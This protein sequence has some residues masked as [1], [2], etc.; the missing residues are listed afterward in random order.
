[1]KTIIVDW[2]SDLFTFSKS[3]NKNIEIT[4]VVGDYHSLS[5]ALKEIFLASFLMDQKVHWVVSWLRRNHKRDSN[6]VDS[7][8]ENLS[9]EHQE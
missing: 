6:T 1:M 2:I 3:V 9:L 5:L 8:L 4:Q 7:A